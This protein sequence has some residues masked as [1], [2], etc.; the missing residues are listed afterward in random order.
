M[1][2]MTR[3]EQIGALVL[4]SLL[5][6]GLVMRF[7]LTPKTP[8][9]FVIESPVEN[10]GEVEESEDKAEEIMVHVAGAVQNPGV[11]T[12]REGARIY[13]ALEAAGGALAEADAHALNL[14]EPLY[15]GR[16][17]NVPFISEGGE[18][19]PSD[20]GDERSQVNINTATAAQLETLPG[21]GPAK[22]SAIVHFREDNGPFTAEDDLAQVSGIGPKTV[23][24]LMEH[25]TLY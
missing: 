11:Y 22:A 17:I 13:E 20:A 25:I 3:R 2:N 6:V 14:A 10:A 1:L 16:R 19:N 9:G 18:G 4:A 12:L 5:V 7:A 15:D 24:A 21:I 23:E 8:D